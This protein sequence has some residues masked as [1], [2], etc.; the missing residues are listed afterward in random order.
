M[1]FRTLNPR[2]YLKVKVKITRKTPYD[3]NTK[4]G[5]I[6]VPLKYLNNFKRSLEMP[7][8]NCEINLMLTWRTGC[9]ISS[10]LKQEHL[11]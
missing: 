4:N 5:E 8:I 1:I 2:N 3:G 11:P 7:L 10:A 9:V 6:V